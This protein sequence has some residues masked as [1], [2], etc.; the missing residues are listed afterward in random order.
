MAKSDIENDIISQISILT[1]LKEK[2]VVR[3]EYTGIK[4]GIHIQL[5]RMDGAY[6]IEE[7]MEVLKSNIKEKIKLLKE[8]L[9]NNEE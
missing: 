8:E 1:V 2:L 7:S 4:N 6:N 5:L 9:F 3:I